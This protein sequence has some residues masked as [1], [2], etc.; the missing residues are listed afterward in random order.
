MSAFDICAFGNSLTAGFGLPEQASLPRQL[1]ARLEADGIATVIANHGIS[2]DTTAGGLGRIQSAL[3]PGPDLVIL[4]LGINDILMGI[5]P[6][7]IRANLEQLIQACLQAKA[8]VL[9]A[10]F[11]AVLDVPPAAGEEFNALYP[12]LARTYDLTLFPDFLGRVAGDP[13]LTLPDGLHPNA[14]GIA[15]IVNRLAP[16]VR[17]VLEAMGGKNI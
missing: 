9:L 6:K 13:E 8:R 3:R 14:R 16:V 5:P 4:E 10:G 1:H 7:R 2:G 15:W 11:T 17:A 12:E